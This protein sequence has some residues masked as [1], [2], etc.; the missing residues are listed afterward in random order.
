MSAMYRFG[1]CEVVTHR[2]LLDGERARPPK[3]PPAIHEH[4]RPSSGS[5]AT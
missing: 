4:R 3:D 5:S 2:D 1:N